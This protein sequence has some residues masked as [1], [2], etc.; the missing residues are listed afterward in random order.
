MERCWHPNPERRPSFLTVI[1][2][3]SGLVDNMQRKVLMLES[4]IL[5]KV[6]KGVASSRL[7]IEELSGLLDNSF[8]PRKVSI[9][10]Y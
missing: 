6:L 1:E 5:L 10:I 2:E 3:L 9:M 4:L 7:V 8:V